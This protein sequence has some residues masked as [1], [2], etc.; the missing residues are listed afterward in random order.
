MGYLA[1][2]PASARL[3]IFER[4]APLAPRDSANPVQVRVEGPDD[5]RV[6]DPVARAR[7]PPAVSLALGL[8]QPLQHKDEGGQ[9]LGICIRVNASDRDGP[10]RAG[11]AARCL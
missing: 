2:P 4:L 11:P 10:G 9:Q 3:G 8:P 5:G 7:L 6:T 1:A